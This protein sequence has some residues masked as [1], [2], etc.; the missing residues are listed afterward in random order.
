MLSP[1]RRRLLEQRVAELEAERDRLRDAFTRF[2]E[3]LAATHEPARL[4]PLAT[5]RLALA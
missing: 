3:S 5:T 4:D 1:R 2:G